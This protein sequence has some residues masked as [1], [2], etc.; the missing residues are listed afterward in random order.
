[1]ASKLSSI[2]SLLVALLSP[3]HLV[4]HDTDCY[5]KIKSADTLT[6][7]RRQKPTEVYLSYVDI[8]LG[9]FPVNRLTQ[10]SR[11]QMTRTVSYAAMMLMNYAEAYLR[12]VEE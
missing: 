11:D 3:I 10:P 6:N 9:S 1:M 5:K 4:H 7:A 2:S 12:R 8:V